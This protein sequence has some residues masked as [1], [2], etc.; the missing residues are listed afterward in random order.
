MKISEFCYKACGTCVVLIVA[1]SIAGWI[2]LSDI[3]ALV[4]ILGVIGGIALVVGIIAS[5]WE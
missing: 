2:G 3:W 5:I 4:A 1:L